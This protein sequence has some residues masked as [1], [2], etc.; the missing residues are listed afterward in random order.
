MSNKADD[1]EY[2]LVVL[3]SLGFINVTAEMLK[4]FMKRN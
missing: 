3:N 2:V 1:P 4:T